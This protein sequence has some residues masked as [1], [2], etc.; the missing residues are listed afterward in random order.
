[1]LHAL[2]V[3]GDGTPWTYTWSSV[4]EI[5]HPAGWVRHRLSARIG[6]DGR[7]LPL[8]SRC[9][10]EAD[11]RRRAE[12]E[13][14]RREWEAM[15]RAAGRVS[16]PRPAMED[17]AAGAGLETVVSPPAAPAEPSDEY[18]AVRA[19]ME[20]RRREKE[21]VEMAMLAAWQARRSA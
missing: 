15:A 19:E 5:R 13:A 9:R 6:P 20:R 21:V 10:A 18:R 1:M 17:T 2:D 3:R 12:Q 14:R 16:S 11:A 4:T 8:P 7:V